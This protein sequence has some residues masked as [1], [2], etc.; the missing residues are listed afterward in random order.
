LTSAS[1]R[2]L[3]DPFGYVDDLSLNIRGFQLNIFRDDR[4]LCAAIFYILFL[5]PL[6]AWLLMGSDSTTDQLVNFFLGIPKLLGGQL[7]LGQLVDQT[8]I[9]WY[10]LGTH[11]SAAVIYSLTFI[12]LS[13]HL[14]DKLG[15]TNSRNVMATAAFTGLTIAAFEFTWMSLDYIY[16]GQHWILTFQWPQGRI[17]DQDI[18]MALPSIPLLADILYYKELKLNLEKKTLALFAGTVGLWHLWINYPFPLQSLAV[19]QWTSSTHFPQT[20]YMIQ[21]NP[22][23]A[24]GDLFYVPNDAV[25]LLNNVTKIVTSL[26]FYNLFKLRRLEHH[27]DVMRTYGS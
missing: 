27:D 20:M 2:F 16:Q 19:G 24:I 7:T 17:I 10:G 23:I 18:L 9:A 3:Q 25:H 5:P 13:K 15:V 22:A 12:G 26:A 11:W 21:T 6:V 14:R 1:K 4:K 8:I